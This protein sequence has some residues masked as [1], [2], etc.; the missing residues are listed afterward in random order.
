MLEAR[1]EVEGWEGRQLGANRRP[2][3]LDRDDARR[4]N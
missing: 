1:D 3:R 2:R 4:G